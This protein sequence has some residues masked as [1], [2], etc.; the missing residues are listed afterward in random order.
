MILVDHMDWT[1]Y[2]V[3]TQTNLLKEILKANE[4]MISL[5]NHKVLCYT[6]LTKT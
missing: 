2:K 1:N 5:N 3:A 6:T 4:G